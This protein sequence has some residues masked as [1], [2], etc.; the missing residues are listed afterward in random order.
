MY[1]VRSG[2]IL[3]FHG[4]A[5]LVLYILSHHGG[6]DKHRRCGVLSRFTLTS[7]NLNHSL[8]QDIL[9]KL[10]YLK[11]TTT[12]LGLMHESHCI[13]APRRQ[14]VCP[15]RRGRARQTRGRRGL[16]RVASLG[17]PDAQ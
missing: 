3:L 10:E 7:S 16:P 17:L 1:R 15:P 12:G 14:R 13:Q 6:R 9:L 4:C 2:C 5:V 8:T 11:N